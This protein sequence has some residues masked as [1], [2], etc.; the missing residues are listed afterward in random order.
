MGVIS[1]KE[2]LEIAKEKGVDVVEIAPNSDPPVCKL[3]NYGKFLYEAEK[4][5]KESRKRQTGNELK[6]IKLRLNIG[7]GDLK[8]KIEQIRKFLTSGNKVKI[9]AM[10]RGREIIYSSR[11]YDL[12]NKIF[13]NIKDIGKYEKK[14]KLENK[15]LTA[16]ISPISKSDLKKGDNL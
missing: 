10:F 1:L 8:I 16:I 9:T 11:G 2:A 5:H 7:E 13:E 14:P 15:N 3:M 6:T 12:I 4:K